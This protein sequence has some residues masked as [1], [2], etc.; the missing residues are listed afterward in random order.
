MLCELLNILLYS[1][2]EE[3]YDVEKD[4]GRQPIAAFA[5]NN[6]GPVDSRQSTKPWWM[7]KWLFADATE[8]LFAPDNANECTAEPHLQW[9]VRFSF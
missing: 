1:R 2:G 7:E 3:M 9:G 6:N 8:R 5:E 4:H